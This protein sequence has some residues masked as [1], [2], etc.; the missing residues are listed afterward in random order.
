LPTTEKDSKQSAHGFGSW[1]QSLAGSGWY[2]MNKPDSIEDTDGIFSISFLKWFSRP[3]K[4]GS[5][6]DAL[7]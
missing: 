4:K 1:L 7:N 2:T 3:T 6:D 5:L